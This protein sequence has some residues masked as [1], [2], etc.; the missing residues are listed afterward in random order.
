MRRDVARHLS[1]YA[2][3]AMA[4]SLPWPLLLVMAW[5]HSG[6]GRDGAWALGLTGAARMVPYIALSW[7]VGRLGDRV[8]RHRLVTA[9][10]LLRLACL[11]VVAVAVAHDRVWLAVAAACVTVACGTP[12]YPAV[13]ASMPALARSA[14]LDPRRATDVLV[15]IESAAWAV[16]PALGGL[17]LLP[18]TRDLVP[19]IAAAMVALSLV[20]VHG[21]TLP[22]PAGAGEESPDGGLT[23]TV[24]G[25]RSVLR[26]LVVVGLVNVVLAAVAMILLPLSRE[27]WGQRDSGF[28]VA[29]AALG[30]GALAAPVLGWAVAGAA[31]RRLLA[32][33]TLTT[34]VVWVGLAAGPALAVPVLAVIGACLVVVESSVT[35][36]IQEQI[37]EH[38]LAGTLGIADS[39]MVLGALLGTV[40]AP[41]VA[42]ALGPRVSLLLVALVCLAT[43]PLCGA[44][45]ARVVVADTAEESDLDPAQIVDPSALVRR[46]RG[47]SSPVTLRYLHQGARTRAHVVRIT[48]RYKRIADVRRG[49]T[50]SHGGAR[51]PT[52][53]GHMTNARE[54][55]SLDTELDETSAGT[56]TTCRTRPTP[57]TRSDDWESGYAD[58]ATAT[59]RS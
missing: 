24:V 50:G 8:R 34:A 2:L 3:A 15:T 7:A 4:V 55:F 49:Q 59:T 19:V 48:G 10:L 57:T 53:D 43:A 22:G 27:V 30:F 1:A 5:D 33:L 39:V 54:D 26:A 21:L 18:S 35:Q 46:R 28:G 36:T 14:D 37:P 6:G 45:R 47:G 56:R 31:L 11:L 17:L 12:A 23:A 40:L 44:V 58:P 16:G 25:S 38:H 42:T 51:R 13:A 41:P 9:T 52:L 20:L 32:L 29:T